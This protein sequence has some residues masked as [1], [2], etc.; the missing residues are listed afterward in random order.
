MGTL[1]GRTIGHYAIRQLIGQGALAQVFLA[2]QAALDRYVAIK[3]LDDAWAGD[4]QVRE[5]FARAAVAMS[6]LRHPAILPVYDAGTFDGRPYFVM[7]YA[8][9]GSLA[10][11]VGQPGA[12]GATW[13]ET[14]GGETGLSAAS[15]EPLPVEEA[16]AI[17]AQIAEA[18]PTVHNADRPLRW[19]AWKSICAWSPCGNR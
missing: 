5:R 4:N 1:L 18:T 15:A 14:M 2:Y 11:R 13:D 16:S 6:N 10:A 8:A 9:Q 17:A 3:V 12:A 19:R 7:D